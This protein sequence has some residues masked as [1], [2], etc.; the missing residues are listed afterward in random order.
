MWLKAWSESRVRFLAIA[1]T[2]SALCAFAVLFEPYIRQH[3]VPIA[4]R[5]REG[6]YTEYIYNLIYSGTAKG[7]YALLVIFLGLGGLQRERA[8][9]TR[10]V[11]ARPAGEPFACGREP[12]CSWHN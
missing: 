10:W 8:N 5:L 9:R 2:L 12:N 11:H 4:L 6:S 3:Q 7:V 1:L